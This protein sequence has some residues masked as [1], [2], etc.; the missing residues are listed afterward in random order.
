MCILGQCICSY[1]M[2]DRGNTYIQE[3]EKIKGGSRRSPFLGNDEFG[4]GI[5]YVHR[6][7]VCVLHD[8]LLNVDSDFGWDLVC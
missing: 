6:I 5:R 4:R 2:K 8:F 1:R 3:K 7:A